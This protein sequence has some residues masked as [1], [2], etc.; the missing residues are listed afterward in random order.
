VKSELTGLSAYGK[1]ALER[2]CARVRGAVE[3]TRA[4]TL[5]SASASLGR[6]VPHEIPEDLAFENLVDAGIDAGETPREVRRI[7][8]SGIGQGRRNPKYVEHGEQRPVLPPRRRRATGVGRLID[9]VLKKPAT[10]EPT[11]RLE[12]E[13]AW[14][15][16]S[17]PEGLAQQDVVDAWDYLSDRVDIPLVVELS[18]AIRAAA[19]ANYAGG[20]TS[21]LRGRRHPLRG[22]RPQRESQSG[23]QPIMPKAYLIS[24]PLINGKQFR[25]MPAN[26]QRVL[27]QGVWCSP[28]RRSEGLSPFRIPT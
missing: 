2:Q 26:A 16:A 1:G 28:L 21:Q 27:V 24:A 14:T 20:G 9:Q 11:A 8:R 7:A 18:R 12:I 5:A 25:E 15:L 13:T 17:V 19:L 4:T 10:H 22:L 6:L 23:G 3:G